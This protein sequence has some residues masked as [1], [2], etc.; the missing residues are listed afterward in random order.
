MRAHAVAARLLCA[1]LPLCAA[2]CRSET[3]SAANLVLPERAL[4]LALEPRPGPALSSPALLAGDYVL[5]GNGTRALIGGMGRA[6]EQQG[7]VLELSH[8]RAGA[9][10]GGR[11][12]ILSPLL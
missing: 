12:P 11:C 10:E 1:L 9:A 2:A 5:S 4:E 6:P 8:E 7:N 3:S